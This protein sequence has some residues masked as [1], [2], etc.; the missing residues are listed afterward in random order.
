MY[1]CTATHIAGVMWINRVRLPIIL[2]SSAAAASIYLFKTAIRHRSVP[3]LSGHPIAG[4]L[5]PSRETKL[6]GTH[7]NR[8][9]S[10]FPVQLT[11]CRIGN[12]TRLIHTL[13]YMLCDDHKY[14][15]TYLL[16]SVVKQGFFVSFFKMKAELGGETMERKE[17]LS[18]G[19]KSVRASS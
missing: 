19:A 16:R 6:S 10:I 12:L 17:H 7:G 15:H 4:R 1:L 2:P 9:I 11:T 5:N 8:E 14:I 13:L 18:S 3:T